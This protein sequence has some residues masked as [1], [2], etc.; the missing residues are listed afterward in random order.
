MKVSVIVPVRDEEDSIRELLDSLLAQTRPPDEIVITDGGSVDA[1]PQIIED[2]KLRGA[3][4]KLIRAGAALP[5]RGRNLAAAEARY[6]WLA[7]TDG[8][9]HLAKNWLEALVAKAQEDES[10]DIVY[11]HVEPVTDTFFTECAAIAYVPPPKPQEDVI[12][13]P[14]FIASSLVRREAWAKVKGFPENLRSAEDLLFMDRLE[15]AGYRAVFEPRAH[16]HWR[17]RAT[18]T[19]TFKRFLVYSLNNIRA[20]LFNQWQARIL[21]RYAML[22]FIFVVAVVIKPSWFWVPFV[23]WLLMLVARAIVSI[24]RNRDCYPGGFFRNVRRVLMVT[25]ILAVLDAAAIIGWL[26]WLFLDAFRGS[27]KTPLEAG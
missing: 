13:R 22:L 4:V 12:S 20:G 19:S 5:G 15:K 25:A 26:Q 6:E 9:I 11:G 16:V 27:R 8:G 14:R 1:T 10:T 21:F 23:L 2:Y 24:W 18:L 7:F 17:L 3:P